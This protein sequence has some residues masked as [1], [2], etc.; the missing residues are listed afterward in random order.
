MDKLK[1]EAKDE[2]KVKL[3]KR[4]FCRNCG[5]EFVTIYPIQQESRIC[6]KCI[7]KLPRCPRCGIV[8]APEWG[9]YASHGSGNLCADCEEEIKASGVS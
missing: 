9:F 8:T 1:F 4:F 5:K 3:G 2:G 6:I 7:K